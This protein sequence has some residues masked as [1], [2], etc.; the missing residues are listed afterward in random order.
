MTE[1]IINAITALAIYGGF[2]VIYALLGAWSN[3]N[4]WSMK[5]DW[6]IWLN[7]VVK[8][9]VIGGSVLGTFVGTFL[10]LDQAPKWGVEITNLNAVSTKVL[11]ALL[12]LGSAT[13]LAKIVQ[14]LA[15]ILGVSKEM[16]EKIQQQAVD[17]P[18]EV[19]VLEVADLPKPTQGYQAEKQQDETGRGAVYSVPIGSYDVFRG[20]VN[21]RGFDIDG[22]YG[23]QCWDGSAL[24]W[25][26]IGRTLSTGGTGAARGCWEVVSARNANAGG[27]FDLIY[28]KTQIKRG[29]VLFFGGSQWGHTG[30]AD[31]NYTGANYIPVLGQN[32]TGDGSG[33]PFNVV[34]VSL[35]SFLGAMRFKN[36]NSTPA[37]TPAPQP[38]PTPT[39]EPTPAPTVPNNPE[40]D[41]E[42]HVGDTVVAWGIGTGDS[43]GGGGYTNNFPE[44]PM[45]VIGI[46]NGKYALNQYNQGTDGNVADV[47]GWWFKEQIRK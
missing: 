11:F 8:Y 29:D 21:G 24:L 7:G 5:W 43:Y 36:W 1:L 33:S 34:N 27:D 41:T 39:P 28:D 2:V 44:T 46:N 22:Y 16:L 17:N 31:S 47:T 18:D 6:K 20:S 35:N 25:Q 32:Q 3:I 38:E 26:Q 19:I 13:M 45:K 23:F 10:L 42:I 40:P 9:V 4:I 15:G 12:A 30:F 14:K 37:P